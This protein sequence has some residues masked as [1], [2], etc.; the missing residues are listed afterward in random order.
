VQ[1]HFTRHKVGVEWWTSTSREDRTG[2]KRGSQTD[3]ITLEGSANQQAI[4]NISR[5]RLCANTSPETREAWIYFLDE[6]K[7]NHHELVQ[8]CV[9]DCIYR[10]WCYEMVSCGYYRTN[11]FQS[12]LALYRAGINDE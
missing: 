1:T 4:I 7:P 2:N 5:K 12:A 9:P 8:C 10:G 11:E 3:P 6:I